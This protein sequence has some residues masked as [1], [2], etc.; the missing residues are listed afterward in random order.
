MHAMLKLIGFVLVITL[1]NVNP[2]LLLPAAAAVYI[3]SKLDE[4]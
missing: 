1:A 3:I 2:F 4:E